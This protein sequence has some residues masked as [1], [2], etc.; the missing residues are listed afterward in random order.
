MRKE[1]PLKEDLNLVLTTTPL[2]FLNL[3]LEIQN[4]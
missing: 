4:V 3:I 2:H 1:I